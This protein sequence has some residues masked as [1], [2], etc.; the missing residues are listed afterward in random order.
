MR[1]W[2]E[3]LSVIEAILWRVLGLISI[4]LIVGA[5]LAHEWHGLIR[6]LRA[7]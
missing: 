5:A 1:K 3:R 4:L 6:S 2:L 7:P